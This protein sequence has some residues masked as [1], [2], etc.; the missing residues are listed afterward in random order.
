MNTPLPFKEIHDSPVSVGR[1]FKTALIALGFSVAC[2]L[3]FSLLIY[4]GLLGEGVI[5]PIVFLVT[6]LSTFLA[7]F[8]NSKSARQYGWANGIAA[9]GIYMVL[10]YLFSI[11]ISGQ[12][13]FCL[14]M[15]AM[16][17]L[18]LLMSAIGG[19]LGIN[20]RANKKCRRA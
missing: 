5:R 16:I 12:F 8:L 1:S 6:C 14:H 17:L 19:I 10:Y 11:I 7:G 2:F 13:L 18:G 3:I 9:G 20:F 4:I 15:A